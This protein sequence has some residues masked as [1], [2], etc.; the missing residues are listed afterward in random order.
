MVIEH[1]VGRLCDLRIN[2][3]CM[4]ERD[5]AVG[6]HIISTRADCKVLEVTIETRSEA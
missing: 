2:P 5:S 1:P 4:F 3:D 6:F